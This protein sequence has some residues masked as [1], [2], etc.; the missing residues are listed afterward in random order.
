MARDY[1]AVLGLAPGRYETSEI[2]HQFFSRRDQLLARLRSETGDDGL[3]Q[4]LDE[5]HLAYAT[6]RD[7]QRQEELRQMIERGEDR[8]AAADELRA[9]IASALEDGLLRYSRRQQILARARELG[10]GE[11]QAQLMIAQVQF[12]DDAVP[13]PRHRNGRSG[14]RRSTG[15]SRLLATGALAFGMFLYLVHWVTR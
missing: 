7:P 12:G 4:Q 13:P 3:R 10:F 15:W 2:A 9:L 11:F 5:V 1:F 6:L 8:P 14:V